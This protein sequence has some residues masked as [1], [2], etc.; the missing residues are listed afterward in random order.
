MLLGCQYHKLRGVAQDTGNQ[1]ADGVFQG[2]GILECE[3]KCDEHYGMGCKS[4]TFCPSIDN[5]N[6]PEGDGT[7]K[8]FDKQLGPDEELN[9][10]PICHSSYQLH[11]QEGILLYAYIQ[12]PLLPILGLCKIIYPLILK[13]G[14]Y[15]K[16]M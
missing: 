11:C 7:C 13:N 12:E 16:Q 9:N 15:E 4:I 2:L 1:L 14:K 10:D 3:Q 5:V 6:D 8:L